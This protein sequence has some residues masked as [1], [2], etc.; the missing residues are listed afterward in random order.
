MQLAC[1]FEQAEEITEY[2]LRG[3]PLLILPSERI[4]LK[5]AAQKQYPGS[6][7]VSADLDVEHA[8]W[9]IVLETV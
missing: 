9:T 2:H 8:D 5:N 6:K 1:S 4:R 7:I 3:E